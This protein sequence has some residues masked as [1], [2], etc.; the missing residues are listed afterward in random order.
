MKIIY[1]NSLIFKTHEYVLLN[2]YTLGVIKNDI[3][4]YSSSSK[5]GLSVM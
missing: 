2:N 1:L 3:K 5:Y 4:S